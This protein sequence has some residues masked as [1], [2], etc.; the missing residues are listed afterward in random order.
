MT[1]DQTPP[2]ET[3][4]PEGLWPEELANEHAGLDGFLESV[5]LVYHAKKYQQSQLQ[6]SVVWDAL[7]KNLNR[8]ASIPRV[9]RS[10]RCG[11]AA[12]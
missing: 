4:P 8:A 12:L 6:L 7:A 2:R 11:T 10:S 1:H 9:F 5:R 3:P